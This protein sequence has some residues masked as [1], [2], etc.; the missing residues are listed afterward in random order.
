MADLYEH[1]DPMTGQNYICGLLPANMETMRAEPQMK[2]E[3]TLIPESEWP[4]KSEDVFEQ[5]MPFVW[6]Q[7][8]QGSCGGHAADAAFTAAWNYQ[9]AESGKSPLEF[10]PTF[11]YGNCNNGVDNG[12][13]PEDLLAVLRDTG[14][15]LRKTVGPGDIYSRNYPKAAYEEALR[16]RAERQVVFHT[17]EEM[18]TLR[19]QN[20]AVFTGIF[21]GNRFTPD[22]NGVIAKWDGSRVGGHATAQI[23]PVEYRS[24]LG[25]GVWTL[26]S[27][28]K[29]W[30][31]GGWA[32][33]HRSFF[34]GGLPVFAGV[35][36][37][38]CRSDPKDTTPTPDPKLAA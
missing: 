8:S 5:Y 30:G 37:T 15:C 10:S 17:F 20:K 35:A 22:A 24:G 3:Y 31:L 9:F 27:W 18:V 21:V 2:D 32:W 23:G 7:G 14:T 6:D 29:R 16:F 33:L 1:N 12:S 13:R 11:V 19:L 25:W 38:S 36:I 4:K 28:S 34:D 26:N